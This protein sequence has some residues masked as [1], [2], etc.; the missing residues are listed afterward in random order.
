MP[1]PLRPGLCFEIQ[2]GGNLD[3]LVQCAIQWTAHLVRSMHPLDCFAIR[4]AGLQAIADKNAPDHQDLVLG[5][6][7]SGDFCGQ[8]AFTCVDLARFQRTSESAEQSASG[9]GNDIIDG[10]GLGLIQGLRVHP[11]M[12]G[13]RAVSPETHRLFLGGEPGQAKRTLLTFDFN[14]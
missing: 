11:V 9:G 6:D 2:L 4:V 12:F 13:N 1:D 8:P 10:R 14:V 3:G 7:L 5:L